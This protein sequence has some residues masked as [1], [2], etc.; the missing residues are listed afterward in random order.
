MCAFLVQDPLHPDPSRTCSYYLYTKRSIADPDPGSGV[1]L[2]PGSRIWNKVFPDLE[3]WI[4]NHFFC[5]L[6]DN[7]LG[8]KFYT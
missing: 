6:N 3:S 8:K 1:F 7:F 2:T 5:E 4:P